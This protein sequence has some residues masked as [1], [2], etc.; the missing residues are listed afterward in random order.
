MNILSNDVNI[1]CRTIEDCVYIQHLGKGFTRLYPGVWFGYE[2]NI[3]PWVNDPD[4]IEALESTLLSN[5]PR[6]KE[7]FDACQVNLEFPV[8]RVF[9][10]VGKYKCFEDKKNGY[11]VRVTN[12]QILQKL[13]SLFD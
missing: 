5:T 8:S 12:Q 4:T 3:Y 7:I 9:Y 2:K 13:E 11:L 1:Q 10:R 6:C